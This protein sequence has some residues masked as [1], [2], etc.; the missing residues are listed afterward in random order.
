SIGSGETGRWTVVQGYGVF[1]DPQSPTTR[2]VDLEIGENVFE[3]KVS[4]GV[5]PE[6]SDQVNIKVN[7]FVIPT[8]ITP[9]EDG[10]NDL[11]HVESIENFT[12]SEL[13]VLDRWGFEVYRS[14]P[15]LNNWGGTDQNMEALTEGTY[16]IILKISDNDIRKGY[17]MIL[18]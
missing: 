4:N 15:Y 8:V 16:Y 2:L 1:A 5:C 6:V 14:A 3:W 17:V 18:R 13:V 10:K 12:A 9:N 7:D 11:F